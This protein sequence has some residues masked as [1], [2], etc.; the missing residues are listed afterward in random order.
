MSNY[1]LVIE[2]TNAL[3]EVIAQEILDKLEEYKNG[4]FDK[5]MEFADVDITTTY[6]GENY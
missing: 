5:M 1:N 4:D 3:P 2:S 6:M